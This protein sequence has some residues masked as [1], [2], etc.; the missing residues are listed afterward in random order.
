MARTQRGYALA[1]PGRQAHALAEHHAR[2]AA[3]GD[4]VGELRHLAACARQPA[5][6][7]AAAD[8]RAQ[9]RDQFLDP[10]VAWVTVH[11]GE[12]ACV[13]VMGGVILRRFLGRQDAEICRIEFAQHHRHRRLL[14]ILHP[15]GAHSDPDGTDPVRHRGRAFE[16]RQNGVGLGCEIIGKI[17][18]SQCCRGGNLTQLRHAVLGGMGPVG[19]GGVGVLEWRGHRFEL[20]SGVSDIMRNP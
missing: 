1:E 20:G 17:E 10:V 18:K 9:R 12:I 4:A 6:D 8:A 5:D 7:E 2:E 3:C 19:A 11:H 15:G 13:E 16:K 14:E